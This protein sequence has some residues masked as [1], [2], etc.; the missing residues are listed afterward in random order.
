MT[1]VIT[2]TRTIWSSCDTANWTIGESDGLFTSQPAPK[3][4][5]GCLGFQISEENNYGGL[6]VT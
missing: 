2:D 3:E 4:L 5:S 6:V 1:V